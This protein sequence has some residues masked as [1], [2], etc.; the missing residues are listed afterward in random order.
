MRT[1]PLNAAFL[2]FFSQI[3]AHR[4]TSLGLELEKHEDGRAAVSTCD[5]RL[6]QPNP[7]GRVVSTLGCFMLALLAVVTLAARPCRAQSPDV[8]PSTPVTC[9]EM[10]NW[11][12]TGPIDNSVP[13]EQ[14]TQ[15]RC[16]HNLLKGF[17]NSTFSGGE[18]LHGAFDPNPLGPVPQGQVAKTAGFPLN[19]N[20]RFIHIPGDYL[21]PSPNVGSSS[22]SLL[23][24][25]GA[26]E[27]TSWQGM[28]RPTI[29]GVV[30]LVT[31]VPLT[32]VVDL[33]LPLDGGAFRL[34][35]TRS[36]AS[37][38][39]QSSFSR[40]PS[41]EWW[42]WTGSGWMAS[43]NP[44]LVVDSSVA[45]VVGNNPKTCW[46]ILDAHHSIPFQ[47]L[48]DCGRYVA[49]PRFR[50]R[51]EHNGTWVGAG[52]TVAPNQFTVSLYDGLLRYTFE[53]DR[54]DV[55]V[56][57]WQ[58]GWLD[59]S[60]SSSIESYHRRPFLPQQFPADDVDSRAVVSNPM[61]DV[62]TYQPGLGLPYLGICTKIE[63]RYGHEVRIKHLEASHESNDYS[64]TTNC[65]ECTQRCYAKGAVKYI[66]ILSGT[67]V[68]WTLVY[69]TRVV[70][71]RDESTS[72]ENAQIW[73]QSL[74]NDQGLFGGATID[75]IYVYDHEIPN[76]QNLRS[77]DLI[78]SPTRTMKVY[79]SN[80]PVYSLDGDE[81]PIDYFRSIPNNPNPGM[82]DGYKH[83]VRYHYH[84]SEQ[85]GAAKGTVLF[86]PILAKTT[87]SEMAPSGNAIVNRRAKMYVY[88][89]G[90][91]EY[92][93]KKYATASDLSGFDVFK[94]P[95]LAAVFDDGGVSALRGQTWGTT[96]DENSVAQWVLPNNV[97]SEQALAHA[98]VQ[99][100][101]APPANQW[102]S[103]N[104]STARLPD[105]LVLS[106]SFLR[107]DTE[108]SRVCVEPPAGL[109]GRVSIGRG[110][111]KESH[112]Q[113]YRLM[114]VPSVAG[115]IDGSS[116]SVFFTNWLGSSL[117]HRSLYVNPFAWKGFPNVGAG[118]ANNVDEIA[119]PAASRLHKAQWIVIIDEFASHDTMISTEVFSGDLS[120]KPG[121]VSRRVVD[122]NASGVV[123]RDYKWDFTPTG[124]AVSG[125]G[126]G[127]QYIYKTAEQYFAGTADAFP[128]R[129]QP[130]GIDDP[131]VEISQ[132][133]DPYAGIRDEMLLL[134]H[135]SVGWSAAENAQAG[136][137]LTMGLT[138]FF[139]YSLH[140]Y[141]VP[142]LDPNEPENL[143]Y[144]VE[145]TAEGIKQ[146]QLTVV[147]NGETVEN[148]AGGPKLYT[149]QHLR[150][151]TA[152]LDGLTAERDVD[153]NF[154][155]PAQTLLSAEDCPIP[156]A[157]AAPP[158]SAWSATH[159]ITLKEI[160]PAVPA[161][162][163]KV[164]GR[165]VIAPPLRMRPGQSPWYYPVTR[166]FCD[167]Q[168]LTPWAANGL[169]ADPLDPQAS[170]SDSACTLA[171]TY[172]QYDEM[173]QVRHIV[174][175]A[176]P[177][178]SNVTERIGGT[179]LVIPAVNTNGGP[180]SAWNRVSTTPALNYVISN[181][182]DGPGYSLSDVYYPNGRRWA[183]R[184][185]IVTDE[186]DA[187]NELI[188][189]FMRQFVINGIEL[190]SDNRLYAKLPGEVHDYSTEEAF[191]TPARVRKVEFGVLPTT[192]DGNQPQT[193]ILTGDEHPLEW[194]ELARVE[195]KPDGNG[196]IA[197][198]DLLEADV[199]GVMQQVGSKLVNELT[200]F[201]REREMDGTIHIVTRNSIGQ[202]MRRYEGTLD[203]RFTGEPSSD[204]MVMKERMEYGQ[205]AND[206]WRPIVV[207]R[208]TNRP[209]WE[210]AAS[211]FA[212]PP[213]TDTDGF[214]T[215]TKYDWRMRPVRV[216]VFDRGDPFNA[217][218][219]QRLQT[220]I[221]Y[222][223]HINRPVL[224]VVYGAGTLPSEFDGTPTQPNFDP[225]TFAP[226]TS[227]PT[228]T[229]I[230]SLTGLKPVSITGMSYGA[231]DSVNERREYD[232]AWTSG[233]GPST[234]PYLASYEFKGQGNQVLFAQ[235]PGAGVTVSVV[236]GIGR[237]AS[238]ARVLPR[239]GTGG[240]VD[241]SF[242][243]ER[244]DNIYDADDNV[245]ETVH[246][247]RV[248]D[249]NTSTTTTPTLG[250]GNAIRTTSMSW[251]DLNN[252]VIA[253][254][255]LGTEQSA[256]FVSNGSPPS[257]QGDWYNPGTKF[258]IDLVNGT[259]FANLN[260]PLNDSFMP[261]DIPLTV[262]RYNKKG[263]RE[264]VATSVA[265][266][267]S[268][269]TTRRFE[270][271]TFAYTG[272]GK[273]AEKIENVFGS[274]STQRKTAYKYRYGQLA[275]IWADRVGSTTSPATQQTRVDFG[276]TSAN[277]GGA[278][279]IE[280][281]ASNASQ[282]PVSKH[283]SY[284][285]AVRSPV[286]NTGL[287]DSEKITFLM[288][289]DFQGRLAERLDARGLAM[290]YE[291][292]ALD[293][294]TS[295]EV[296]SY[297]GAN[298]TGTFYTGYPS[299]MQFE[300]TGAPVDRIGFVEYIYSADT[301]TY[302][303]NSYSARGGSLITS[304]KLE[305]DA[306]GH[307][308][309]DW[310]SMGTNITSSTVKTVYAWDM[311]FSGM[312]GLPVGHARL[313]SMTYPKHFETISA[314]TVSMGY[315]TSGLPSDVLSRIE[316]IT[317]TPTV[318]T[319]P[320]GKVAA[321]TY[322]G[323]DRRME[324]RLADG[325][326]VQDL[327]L[328]TSGGS[329]G[330]LAYDQFG[331]R[332]DINYR[333][334]TASGGLPLTHISYT[335]DIAG[336]RTVATRTPRPSGTP[337]GT[338]NQVQTNAYDSLQRL[339]GMEY[340]H[341]VF[342]GGSNTLLQHDQWN[343]DLLG[344][345]ASR[346][347]TSGGT[348]QTI[349]NM[350]NAQNQIIKISEGLITLADPLYDPAGNLS[351][352]GTYAYQY[353]AWNRLVQVNL[354]HLG[355]VGESFMLGE[356][357]PV[358]QNIILD[359]LIKHYTYDGLGRLVRTQSPYPM[360]GQGADIRTERFYYD[361]VRRIQELNIDPLVALENAMQSGDS[362]IAAVAQT[363][364][365]MSSDELDGSATPVQLEQSQIG[366]SSSYLT[367]PPV[368]WSNSY[369]AR[370]YIWGSGDEGLDELLV[371]YDENRNPWWIV[372]DAGLDVVAQIDL[373]ASGST[374]RV[375]GEWTYDAY[376]R[377]VTD[378]RHFAVSEPHAG[379]KG[380]FFDRLDAG[381][382][383]P[384]SFTETPRLEHGAVVLGYNRNRTLHSG[385]GRFLQKDPNATGQLLLAQAF[386]GAAPRCHVVS[387]SLE[388][389]YADGAN[390]FAYLRNSPTTRFDA[391]GLESYIGSMA[392]MAIR[393]QMMRQGL[394]GGISQ[395]GMNGA[396]S[397]LSGDDW[398]QAASK[399]GS[400]FA[401]GFVTGML[402]GA[403]A[404][405]PQCMM[406]QGLKAM[407]KESVRR[408]N[409]A[410]YGASGAL[411]GGLESLY[412]GGS[413]IEAAEKAGWGAI[414][415]I[416]GG[417]AGN[418]FGTMFCFVEGT[419]V[420]TPDGFTNI[421]KLRVGD[422]VLTD[423]PCAEGTEVNPATWRLLTLLIPD[424]V[425]KGQFI[426]I[427]TL[428]SPQW[429]NETGAKPGMWIPYDLPEMGI[430][431]PA[432]VLAVEACPA[433]NPGTG[434]VVLSTYYRMANNV[435]ELR[436]D[437]LDEP[438][439][440][441]AN[442]PFFSADRNEWVEVGELLQGEAVKTL[443]GSVQ[444][445]TKPSSRQVREVWNLEVEGEHTYAISELGCIAHNSYALSAEKLGLKGY[446]H[447][448]GTMS[449]ND[450]LA[451][452]KIDLIE[453]LD[454][455]SIDL[456]LLFE[457]LKTAAKDERAE[458]LRI[459]CSLANDRL[460]R[461]LLK[462]AGF[463]T[464]GGIE[465]LEIPL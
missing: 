241:Y 349:S 350:V 64:G 125:S 365:S 128:S 289:Y 256:G 248:V 28:S 423:N 377:V 219:T 195:Y 198:A 342:T 11:V 369:V 324:L 266:S 148:T 366:E 56:H 50:A 221:T 280:R 30:D 37:Q 209:S 415:G 412:A 16:W 197:V 95:W 119:D 384:Y 374:A 425:F 269:P 32:Q 418:F 265:P 40:R 368:A 439:E 31:G 282:T 236:D 224:T 290:R 408:R 153:I 34:V 186:R 100:E 87:T 300:N 416:V 336:N 180:P 278:D 299:S 288:R 79:G 189:P 130:A 411:G 331:R 36:Q 120:T 375:V 455:G 14:D 42:D 352:D 440:V 438:V 305:C 111:D 13:C 422:R 52:W 442:H 309:A 329:I 177:G 150:R 362:G 25:T 428:K 392:S 291:Y 348:T 82:L 267:S 262:F 413:W 159:T 201:R 70:A 105:P 2:S 232:V 229:Q 431:G 163:S 225:S 409:L 90:E 406:G 320:L 114:S 403:I 303:A 263:L 286:A 154:L 405:N 144:Q 152:T 138:K 401:I 275:E 314:R 235:T 436:V 5:S 239:A 276:T 460:L 43:E 261:L 91:S 258:K 75:S 208:Y 93:L 399:A 127:E 207:R 430:E 46:L 146:G 68:K 110:R 333:Q 3:A 190:E 9:T 179:T 397:L 4:T 283:G 250:T 61:V 407:F 166:V 41:D 338:T 112:F 214:A 171:L 77:D 164:V 243:L 259:V 168:G 162:E 173:G 88:S 48:E 432:E 382:V 306:R 253:T 211:P 398:G 363:I 354:A 193:L 132:P 361:G 357:T 103:P 92:G 156:S 346:A 136:G 459:E 419:P 35:R 254:A 222:L 227:T 142:G 330:I 158:S 199:G 134:E 89:D 301:R 429:M 271:T 124:A 421:D 123:L 386:H 389:W 15:S 260:T 334:D 317:T 441:T 104:E 17:Y 326:I 400:G 27:T 252:R 340:R 129:P 462:R 107:L 328:S 463:R 206:A 353:D 178:A 6:S 213:A 323:A 102:P 210:M 343:L 151:L 217:T 294:L 359:A 160:D 445:R 226:L 86:P 311:Q 106:G 390:V 396:S 316:L 60:S 274:L 295:I 358:P 292:D 251:H 78:I 446:K 55:P 69:F 394:S 139:Q 20:L 284:V 66:E 452:V 296:G 268:Q 7:T 435:I 308:V 74:A 147:Q 448:I 131:L 367:T 71:D 285:R 347:T 321:F 414:S 456:R 228:A 80:P 203:G 298:G 21:P 99:F 191:G 437:G 192:E 133:P 237:I 420:A 205:T 393:S 94:L 458:F 443:A 244:T 424:K 53:V 188:P 23:P 81:D 447:L 318:S 325:K 341:D 370:E 332:R 322:D 378:E 238:T 26:T 417:I 65:R 47:L 67:T 307:L 62:S 319:Y 385:L 279:V 327:G 39:S 380:L 116:S 356:G 234:P 454:K 49:P 45:D 453:S 465:F 383:D 29:A 450:N 277:N 121:L 140:H 18:K 427:V 387:A 113:I 196:R 457:A 57:E 304:T 433:I 264:A 313:A 59:N 84:Y 185:M 165:L 373:G 272:S 182:Y 240:T 339:I 83:V 281:S 388:S 157:S 24:S 257:R 212:S 249:A 194:T 381:V 172:T 96:V 216:D 167:E 155:E 137:G 461:V 169:V 215:V 444:V 371:Q 297:S 464:E 85:D 355:P 161:E 174:A 426:E 143:N 117:P 76:I 108:I 12:P 8:F 449:K 98:A 255:E 135:R 220:T 310:Q 44:L 200:D 231:D 273:L 345:W 293:R 181:L 202:V 351:F 246:W 218:A 344:N 126:L 33:S 63:D 302:T 287:A 97:T 54:E 58:S 233:S 51:L 402:G 183:M 434:R 223:D 187:N 391:M 1:R 204:N 242:E 270:I 38:L 184:S 145:L 247:E 410:A 170:A 404:A 118:W 230:L 335:F 176:Q 372:Q 175:D 337:T 141:S 109:A 149:S 72:A 376:G 73:Y 245:H 122:I 22:V 451:I 101:A 115:A 379:H 395:G 10:L 364:A 19:V 312:G 315:G 360:A